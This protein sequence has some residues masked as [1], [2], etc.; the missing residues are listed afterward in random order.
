MMELQQSP[1]FPLLFAFLNPAEPEGGSGEPSDGGEL[2]RRWWLRRTPTAAL[3]RDDGD[4][5][6]RT[7]T[8]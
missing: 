3:W 8:L 5:S 7:M 6:E 2:R 4:V 1:L